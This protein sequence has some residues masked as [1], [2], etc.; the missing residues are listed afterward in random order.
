MRIYKNNVLLIN[1]NY[2]QPYN[3]GTTC[4]YVIRKRKHNICQVRVDFQLF[5]IAQ[6]D[7]DGHCNRDYFTIENG[8]SVIPLICGENRG[9]HVYV[10]FNSDFPVTVRV[11]TS[12]SFNFGRRWELL[13]TQIKCGSSNIAPAGCLQYH[14]NSSGTIKSFNYATEV[15]GF[16]NSIGIIGTR[17]ISGLNYNICFK[18]SSCSIT[19]TR[20]SF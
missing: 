20:V 15:S 12:K 9:Q 17:Q 18:Q 3:N 2:P 13:V 5:S 1:P 11:F 10:D 4:S 14:I 16:F 8:A 7:G 19:Y 6:P